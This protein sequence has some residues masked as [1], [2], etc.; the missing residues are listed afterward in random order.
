MRAIEEPPRGTLGGMQDAL[1]KMFGG[2]KPS[3]FESPGKKSKLSDII[4]GTNDRSA[5]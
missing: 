3:A 5:A 4:Y 1:T 2:Q